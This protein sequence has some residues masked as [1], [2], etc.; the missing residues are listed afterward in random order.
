MFLTPDATDVFSIAK[1]VIQEKC[2]SY[3]FTNLPFPTILLQKHFNNKAK[4]VPGK[5]KLSKRVK[6]EESTC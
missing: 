5:I 6:H 4:T 1:Q 3:L 2:K